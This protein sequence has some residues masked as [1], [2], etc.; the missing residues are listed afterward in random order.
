M[1]DFLYNPVTISVK[2]RESS[3]N[4]DQ[5][6]VKLDGREKVDVLFDLLTQEGFE[7]VLVFGRTKWGAEKLMRNLEQRRIRVASIHGNKKQNQR[8]KAIEDFKNSRIQ[9]LIAT[10]IASRGLDI[11]DVTHVINFDLPESY[12]DYIHRIGRTGRANKKGK[13]LTFID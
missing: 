13:A 8:Q 7:K 1:Q 3:S 5:D 11:N 12:E 6:I 4:V 2:T 10:D 9:V